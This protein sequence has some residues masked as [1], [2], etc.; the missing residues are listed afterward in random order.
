MKKLY[1]K[2]KKKKSNYIFHI[3]YINEINKK[4]IIKKDKSFELLKCM[5]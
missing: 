3:R 5:L 2:T 4:I 1:L